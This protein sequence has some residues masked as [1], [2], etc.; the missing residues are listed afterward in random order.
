MA[1]VA[2]DSVPEVENEVEQEDETRATEE[3]C[4]TGEAVQCKTCMKSFKHKRSLKTH[5]RIHTGETFDC[6][7]CGKSFTR[8]SD[9]LSHVRVVHDQCFYKCAQCP[10]VYKSMAG[11]RQHDRAH[12]GVYTHLCPFCGEGFNYKTLFD[13]HI[14][15]HTG[16][17]P[18]Q[19]KACDKAFNNSSNLAQHQST[20]GVKSGTIPCPRC[21][22]KF[23]CQKYLRE[24]IKIHNDP[25]R[26]QCSYCGDL[27]SHRASLAKHLKRKHVWFFG[28]LLS[29]YYNPFLFVITLETPQCTI[30]SIGYILHVTLMITQYLDL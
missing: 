17:S 9:L 19:C 6:A 2:A 28:Y 30:I 22:K 18:F 12:Q 5:M 8:K 27:F 14:A 13:T 26:Y 24:H 20:C 10:K 7:Q 1:Q 21:P 25:E 29:C 16:A 4:S 23:K 15:K 3:T 11:L